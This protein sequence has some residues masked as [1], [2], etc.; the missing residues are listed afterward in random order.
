MLLVFVLA[1]PAH[2]ASAPVALATVPVVDQTPDSAVAP[3]DPASAAVA[4]VSA[5]PDTRPVFQ[6]I[7]D[8][9]QDRVLLQLEK[10]KAQ[11]MLDLD[12]M[13]KEQATLRAG[14]ASD[15]DTAASAKADA[16]AQLQK[17][18]EKLQQSLTTLQAQ[19]EKLKSAAA[20]PAAS[21]A[22]TAATS[23]DNTGD[24]TP[25][26]ISTRMRLIQIIGAGRELQATIEDIK[27]GQRRKISVG[28][29]VD[30]YDVRSIS[31]DEGVVFLKD[32]VTETLGIGNG[33]SG[34]DSGN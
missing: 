4:D 27:S 22:S 2:A 19:M 29:S 12:R 13:A 15:T 9:E 21:G 30:G 5:A 6:Q 11:L 8:L 25:S 28:R 23:S 20:A 14:A 32:G 1:V 34:D 33:K 31:L 17:D 26:G 7:A 24:N 16:I 18:N 3:D 10:E